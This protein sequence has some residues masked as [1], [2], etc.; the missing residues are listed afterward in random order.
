MVRYFIRMSMLFS[1]VFGF[2]YLTQAGKLIFSESTFW[3]TRHGINLAFAGVAVSILSLAYMLRKYRVVTFGR[4]R[5][6]IDAH[7]FIGTAGLF[8]IIMHASYQFIAQVPGWATWA[9]IVI[10]ISGLFGY[11]IYLTSARSLLDEVGVLVEYDD[12]IFS[13][14]TSTAFRFWHDIHF[15]VSLAAIVLAVAHVASIFVFRGRY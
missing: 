5:Y 4:L 3:T 2:W 10:G 9:M 6:W 15:I 12:I 7:V 1:A 11:H 13:T 14:M 8:L